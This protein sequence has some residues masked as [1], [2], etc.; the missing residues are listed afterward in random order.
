M[1]MAAYKV[2]IVA[3]AVVIRYNAG[4]TDVDAVLDSY[5]LSDEDRTLV[6]AQIAVSNPEI[7]LGTAPAATTDTT[8][9]TA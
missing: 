4:E 5:N 2:R 1:A 6:L 9:A 8:T 7:P 3:R